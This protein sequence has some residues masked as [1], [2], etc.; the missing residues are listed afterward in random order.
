MASP[1]ET[2]LQT[3]IKNTVSIYK[4][5]MASGATPYISNED[6]L[7]QSLEGDHYGDSMA[8]LRTAR[9]TLNSLLAS[10]AAVLAPMFIEYAKIVNFPKTDRA[11]I[12]RHLR[13]R[14][15]DTN[16]SVKSRGFTFG[17]VA[18]N[19]GNLGNGTILRITVD[20]DGNDIEATHADVKTIECVSDEHS[21]S[22]E[23]E[24]VF[25]IRSGVRLPDL[26]AVSGSGFVGNLAGL[27]A[28]TS[29]QFLENPSFSST[30]SGD[31]ISAVTDIT[32]WTLDSITSVSID[33]T[34]YY[35][36]SV[37]DATPKSLAF[38][39]NRTIEQN[40]NN[41]SSWFDPN[42][43]Y[44]FQ[45]AYN[46]SVFGASGSNMRVAL[47]VGSQTVTSPAI[48][49]ATG[50][51]VLRMTLN[52]LCYIKNWNQE[53]PLFKIA[54]TGMDTTGKALLIDDCII[55]PMKRHDAL[56]YAA[57]G[58]ST[59]FLARTA[60]LD[61]DT[62]TFTDSIATDSVIQ[63]HLALMFGEYLR[64]NSAGAETWTD[65]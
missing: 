18:A 19:G 22:N 11:E 46:A 42:T 16:Q 5:L 25:E 31:T 20:E 12:F 15:R 21:G 6:T 55:G 37:G 45:I 8:A 39:A 47:T 48:T 3:Q 54:L 27:S 35:R 29:Q 36:G 2:E 7:V 32:G 40:F 13:R 4:H 61:G 57:V 30:G 60:S 65:P 10:E 51:T 50:W 23:H 44:V 26:L 62:F 34:N 33:E 53:N 38:E 49:S 9:S 43:P 59:P 58:G 1:T 41:A 63:R 24:E 28:N 56:W 17:A 64:S 14:F 52:K